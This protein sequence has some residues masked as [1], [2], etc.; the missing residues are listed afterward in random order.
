M[1]CPSCRAENDDT[2]RLCLACR[3]PLRVV[4]AGFQVGCN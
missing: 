4:S 2:A 1:L 3:T